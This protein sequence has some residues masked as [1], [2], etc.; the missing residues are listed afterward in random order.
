MTAISRN[1][2]KIYIGDAGTT[3][4]ELAVTAGAIVGQIKNY[5]KS[6][7]EKDVES[8]PVFGGFVDKEKPVSQFELSLE[9]IPSLD[10]DASLFDAMIYASDS[11]NSG[12][13]TSSSKTALQPTDKVVV[14]EAND[15]EGNEKTTA[16]NNCNVTV[17]DISHNA[18][19]NRSYNM[20][21]KLAPETSDGQPNFM[22]ADVAASDLVEFAALD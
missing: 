10:T 11:T 19:D 16:W 21:L 17:L 22:T 18:D 20:T 13:Y 9:I 7:G 5:D 6:G 2:V 8:D 15:G 14:I 3:G 1:K 4:V 12:Y